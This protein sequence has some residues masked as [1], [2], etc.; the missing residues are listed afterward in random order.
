MRMK[1]MERHNMTLENVSGAMRDDHRRVPLKGVITPA[2]MG[3]G[4]D[5]QHGCGESRG[6]LY[7]QTTT[8]LTNTMKGR[9]LGKLLIN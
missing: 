2:E 9:K 4:M 5:H 3:I 8:G 6:A 7:A 1:R